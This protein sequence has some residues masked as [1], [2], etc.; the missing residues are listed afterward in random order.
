MS[1][2]TIKSIRHD[3]ALVRVVRRQHKFYWPYWKEYMPK[4]GHYRRPIG[5][6]SLKTVEVQFEDDEF[7]VLGFTV[8]GARRHPTKINRLRIEL[9]NGHVLVL[10]DRVI[11]FVRDNSTHFLHYLHNRRYKPE[12]KST[13]FDRLWYS[14]YSAHGN[15]RVT[16]PNGTVINYEQ[17]LHLKVGQVVRKSM[18]LQLVRCRITDGDYVFPLARPFGEEWRDY[19]RIRFAQGITAGNWLLFL[20]AIIGQYVQDVIEIKQVRHRMQSIRKQQLQQQ[21]DQECKRQLGQCFAG[22]KAIRSVSIG[23][24][25][26]FTLQKED[27]LTY[28]VD[29]PEYAN[30]LYVFDDHG[31]AHAWASRAISWREARERARLVR[32]HR[33]DWKE[34][35]NLALV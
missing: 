20:K 25:L 7:R 9:S 21:R 19:S 14:W 32:I 28:V 15:M 3:R 5:E 27:T 8:P 34:Q 13:A 35:V 23:K 29:S 17:A 16:L 30:A 12:A 2:I 26:L 10:A 31:D 24:N 22:H 1:A 6:K 18:P 4:Y 11:R 33:G